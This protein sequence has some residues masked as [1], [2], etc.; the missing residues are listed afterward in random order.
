LTKNRTNTAGLIRQS[1]LKQGIV[2][3][4]FPATSRIPSR[5]S[6]MRKYG[7]ARATIDR[8]VTELISEGIL[9]GQRGS[10]TYVVGLS[11]K[12]KRN[13]TVYVVLH[14]QTRIGE[15]MISPFLEVLQ[16]HI[17]DGLKLKFITIN[18]I[19]IN[20]EAYLKDAAAF[21]FCQLSPIYYEAAVNLKQRNYPVLLMNRED[22]FFNFVTTDLFRAYE[23]AL[24]NQS[25]GVGAVFRQIC[26]DDPYLN[27][28]RAGLFRAI[29][30]NPKLDTR[31]EW[32]IEMPR[33]FGCR[34]TVKKVMD[35]LSTNPPAWLAVDG[36]LITCVLT[37][38]HALGMEIGRD[39]NLL[40][41]EPQE[42][43]ESETGCII[44]QQDYRAMGELA[45]EWLK[46]LNRKEKFQIKVPPI[47]TKM[48]KQGSVK[49]DIKKDES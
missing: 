7:F 8:G 25:G 49:S 20:T 33:S 39:I 6:L 23:K 13:R 48:F 21:I 16:D 31:P 41:I 47:I 43:L 46:K 45:F 10:G 19:M 36:Y 27:E 1:L 11:E 32:I 29:A 24:S 9:R 15:T 2:E 35:M 40:L 18:D 12:A 22:S 44:M 5:K 34:K 30:M 14:R 37:T 42:D 4:R 17:H 3:N 26:L 28:G 38:I